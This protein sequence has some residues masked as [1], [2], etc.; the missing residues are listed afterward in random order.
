MRRTL[1]ESTSRKVTVQLLDLQNQ[2]CEQLLSKRHTDVEGVIEPHGFQPAQ[3]I[4]IYRNNISS[5]LADTLADIYPVSCAMVGGDFFRSMASRYNRSHPSASG[6]LHDYG[7]RLPAF[8]R[9]M[10]EL[11]DLPF[12]PTIAEIDW[13][14]HIAYH[15]ASLPELG[16][17]SLNHCSVDD[18]EHLLFTLHPAVQA[19]C[20]EFPIYDIWK[21]AT[22]DDQNSSI[23]D[24]RSG[25]QQV[26]VYRKEGLVRVANI[27]IDLFKIFERI[28]ERQTLGKIF[29]SILKSNPNYNLQ[30]GLY[31]LFTFNAISLITVDRR[32]QN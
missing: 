3:R 15:A 11:A 13:A 9:N 5:T 16:I 25:S 27:D 29:P 18:Y 10:P 22:S 32:Q 12:L 2:F 17:D 31:Q 26:L 23:P 4:N 24:T 19:I 20:S 21:F 30:Q 7:T 1:P 28:G 8:M 6:N 14:C